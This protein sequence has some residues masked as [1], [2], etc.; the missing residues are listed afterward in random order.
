M[1]TTQQI[2]SAFGVALTESQEATVHRYIELLL[3]WNR[4]ISLTAVTDR[5]EIIRRHFGESFFAVN[6]VPLKEGRLADVGSGAGFPGAAIAILQPGIDVVLIESNAKK[7]AFL[8]T[9]RSELGLTNVTVARGRVEACQDI[10]KSLRFVTA[11]AFGPY[12]RLLALVQMNRYAS[13][14]AVLWLGQKDADELASQA[15]WSW[16]TAIQIPGSARRVLLVGHPR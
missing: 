9:V 16:R 2:L 13:L 4:K 7:A 11:R 15:R 14:E 10:L 8:E 5:D 1:D 3:R 12:A 6:A